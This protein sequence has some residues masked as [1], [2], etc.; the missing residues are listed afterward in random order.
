MQSPRIVIPLSRD[1]EDTLRLVAHG[2]CPARGLRARDLDQLARLGLIDAADGCVGLTPFG[3]LRL[4]QIAEL[5]L[6]AMLG[7]AR[8][9]GGQAL[10]A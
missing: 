6:Q 10:A 5:N 3:E 7:A 2:R 8:R 1:E 9:R 4:A